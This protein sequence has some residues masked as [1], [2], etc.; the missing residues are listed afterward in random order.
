MDTIPR[1]LLMIMMVIASMML[2]QSRL[3]QQQMCFAASESEDGAPSRYRPPVGHTQ[4][5]WAPSPAGWGDI[6]CHEIAQLVLHFE[7]DTEGFTIGIRRLGYPTSGKRALCIMLY[8]LGWPTRLGDMIQV[9]FQLLIE[10]FIY[11]IHR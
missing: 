4:G 2:L 6:E 9:C 5:A 10:S 11:L 7:L 8:R 3:P 1:R